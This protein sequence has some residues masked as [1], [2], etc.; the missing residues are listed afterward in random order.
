MKRLFWLVL[1]IACAP[2]DRPDTTHVWRIDARITI[3]DGDHLEPDGHPGEAGPSAMVRRG[4]ALWVTYAH[5]RA[6][7]P[8]GPGWLAEH[9]AT[10]LARRRLIK[11]AHQGAEC[12]N[13]VA[14][15]LDD[16]RAH[17]A[18]AGIN[19]FKAPSDDGRVMSV[20]LTTGE[21]LT[22]ARVGH[23]PGALTRVNDALWLG[24]G[25]V[26]GAWRIDADNPS[27][28]DHHQPCRVDATHQGYV[29]DLVSHGG[30]LFAACFNDDTLLELDPTTG[31]VL[32][33]LATGDAPLRLRVLG[34]KL[35][36]LDNLGGT[37]TVVELAT[38]PASRPAAIA[39]GAGGE[40][41][42]NDPQG[43]DGDE[44]FAGVTNS[45][46]GTFVVVDTETGMMTSALDLK[47]SADAASNF[48][49]SVTYA[50]GVFH[51]LVPGLELDTN[52]VPGEL[53]RIV[54]A[55]Q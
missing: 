15:V 43:I 47:P 26:G 17:V 7:Q 16:D 27:A 50:D 22:T 13:P 2:A 52:D 31:E 14:L 30:R 11:L 29:S 18:C 6:Y 55:A 53:I 32:H 20:S 4:D 45:A 40:Q 24:D 37:M 3:E 28:A 35:Y 49:T 36:V 46:W 42:G 1:A 19:S 8:A 48:P 5:L 23:S 41:G 51:V 54:K 25:E 10:T 39:L 12:R 44:G 33:T 38:P 34:E 9:D 21:V